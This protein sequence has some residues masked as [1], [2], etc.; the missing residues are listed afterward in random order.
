MCSLIGFRAGTK[1]KHEEQLEEYLK[2]LSERG[3][4]SFGYFYRTKEGEIFYAKSLALAPIAKDLKTLPEGAWCF[5]HARKASAGMAGTTNKDKLERAHPVASDDES[6]LLL[7]NGT[8]AS[9]NDTVYGSISDSQGLATLLS[10]MWE[11]RKILAKEIGVVLYQ[12]GK[13]IYLYKDGERPLVMSEDNTIFASEPISDKVKWKNIKVTTDKDNFDVA[14][15]F[16]AEDLG[17]PC[18][19]A[20]EIKFNIAVATVK[21]WSVKGYPKVSLCTTCKKRHIDMEGVYTACCVCVIEGKYKKVNNTYRANNTKHTVK[22]TKVNTKAKEPSKGIGTV[23]T[24]GAKDGILQRSNVSVPYGEM[25]ELFTSDIN[26]L[27]TLGYDDVIWKG[28]AIV[29]TNVY[30][31]NLNGAIF[32]KPI[33]NGKFKVKVDRVFINNKSLNYRHAFHT[34]TS[35]TIKILGKLNTTAVY[36]LNKDMDLTSS[37]RQVKMGAYP[38]ETLVTRGEGAK[39]RTALIG[40]KELITT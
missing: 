7:H 3:D 12:R 31:K 11:D 36:M 27:K 30:Y 33:P 25:E 35:Q 16:S 17:I 22:E 28:W 21:N 20:V 18:D 40:F 10:V 32:I 6:I 4:Q 8:K 23:I 13:Q 5:L 1:D 34:A 29:K 9:I 19:K 14:L 26:I 39:K 24:S 15:D 2:I 37:I 38:V